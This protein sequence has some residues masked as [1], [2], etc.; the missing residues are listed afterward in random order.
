M[1]GLMVYVP[2]PEMFGELSAAKKTETVK[3]ITKKTAGM[4]KYHMNFHSHL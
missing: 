3:K 1:C 4:K 2:F